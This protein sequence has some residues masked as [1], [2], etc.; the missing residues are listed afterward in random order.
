MW[1]DVID[2]PLYCVGIWSKYI[3]LGDRHFKYKKR[4]GISKSFQRTQD[5]TMTIYY[6]D[7]VAITSHHLKIKLDFEKHGIKKEYYINIQDFVRYKEDDQGVPYIVINRQ[8]GQQMFWGYS[9]GGSW[10]SPNEWGY[11]GF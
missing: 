7:V 8:Q 6:V 10:L 5:N 2:V 1:N 4:G 11:V 3:E 9:E